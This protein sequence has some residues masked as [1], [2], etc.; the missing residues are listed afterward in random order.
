MGRFFWIIEY[1]KVAAAYGFTMYVWPL[2][3]FRG[4]LK[5]KSVTYRF[6]FCTLSMTTI[7]TTEMAAPMLAWLPCSSTV[8]SSH[9]C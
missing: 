6:L 8:S 5:E 7:I 1:F 3:V 4:H 2:V 9:G